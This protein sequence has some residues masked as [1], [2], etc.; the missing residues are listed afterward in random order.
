MGW[1]PLESNP[2]VFNKWASQAGLDTSSDCFNDLYSLDPEMLAMIPRPVKAV[3]LVFPWEEARYRRAAEDERLAKEGGPKIDEN[4]FWMK[5]TIHNACGAMAMIHG[6]ANSDVKLLPS[7][8]LQILLDE[9]RNKPTSERPKVL[10]NSPKF[11]EIHA[12][13]ANAGQC[14]PAETDEH[15]D[16]GYICFVVAPG[17]K[18]SEGSSQSRVVELDGGR[19]GP[20]D[21]GEC[22]DDL[23]LAVVRLVKEEFI[24]KSGSIKFNMMYLGR[25][26]VE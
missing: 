3:I 8:P 23:L 21:R 16:Q 24:G 2:E 22:G 9:C 10:E 20:V 25:P 6:I 7:S 18:N 19:A 15:P 1:V 5:Q 14:R 11:A 26:L 17:P 12:S 13:V 4:V